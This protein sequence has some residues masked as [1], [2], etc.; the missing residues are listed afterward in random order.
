MN[1]VVKGTY[2][3]SFYRRDLQV[4]RGLAVLVVIGFHSGQ[5][6]LP[7]GYLGVD[8]FF[9]ISGF[10]ITPMILNYLLITNGLTTNKSFLNNYLHFLENRFYR[11]FPALITSLIFSALLIF[12]LAPISDH[13]R[14]AKQGIFA[15]FGLGNIGA[16]LFNGN[17]FDPNPNPL[18]HL[19]FLAVEIQFY[20]LFPLFLFIFLRVLINHQKLLYVN[21][22]FVI[23]LSFL[24]FANPILMAPLYSLF[25]I[26]RFEQISFYSTFDRVWQFGLGGLTYVCSTK[27]QIY[28]QRFGLQFLLLLSFAIILLDFFQ[29]SSL[30]N[31]I[32]VTCLSALLILTRALDSIPK[33][34]QVFLEFIGYRSYSIYLVHMPI[35]YVINYSPILNRLNQDYPVLLTLFGL[36]LS[37]TFGAWN[38]VLIE[39][40][41]RGKTSDVRKKQQ[42]IQTVAIF[43]FALGALTIM[44]MGYRSY[45]WGLETDRK[46]PPPYV[47]EFG[48]DCNW[49]SSLSPV[50]ESRVVDPNDTLI[51]IGDSY[52]TQISQVV[53]EVGNSLGWNVISKT[54]ANCPIMF[55]DSH[56]SLTKEC[57]RSNLST[58]NWVRNNRP[59]AIVVS[60]RVHSGL[61]LKIMT[62]SIYKLSDYSAR[63]LVIGNTPE[64]PDSESFMKRR[65]V[66]MQLAGEYLPPKQ[67]RLESMNSNSKKLSDKFLGEIQSKGVE[68]LDLWSLF[69]DD[70]Y[71]RRH[72][73]SGWLYF[74]GNHLSLA[75]ANRLKPILSVVIGR[76]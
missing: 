12:L 2:K 71:C 42:K 20:A 40:R 31:T 48:S 22:L 43:A 30:T 17:Y 75:G 29:F 53:N 49:E 7:L 35:L 54:N 5:T 50:C 33:N 67:F 72:D 44:M 37:I 32:L 28:T 57:A 68:V 16:Y 3:N 27:K 65:P 36:I 60:N 66:L 41:F 38:F 70:L 25:G 47:E 14:F 26:E 18:I 9:V 13:E 76:W 46:T 21:Y 64:F 10:V 69:C 61:D 34:I 19:W 51:L 39:S 4:F 15:L 58:L 24:S 45:Y 6:F 74:D 52:A 63:V 56:D 11:L 73:T 23:M 62:D 1:L 59:G 55:V 8:T